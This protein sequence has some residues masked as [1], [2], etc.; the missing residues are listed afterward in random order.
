MKD[1]FIESLKVLKNYTNLSLVFVLTFASWV[2]LLIKE[3]N[4]ALRTVFVIFPV[5][6]MIIFIL[7][8]TAVIFNKIGMDND[9]YYRLLWLIPI[10]MITIYGLLKAFGDTPKKRIIASLAAAVFIA[11]FGKCVYQSPVFFKSE[12]LYGI[13]KQTIDIVDFIKADAQRDV[14]YVL[15]S[16][17]LITT[18]RQ[19]DPGIGMPYGRDTYTTTYVETN[20]VYEVYEMA[21]K[22]NFKNLLEVS[23]DY[24]V[25]YIVVYITKPTE[26]DPL[27][28]G[29]EYVG[30]VNDHLIYKDPVITARVEELKKYYE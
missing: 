12:N 6:M 15:P 26:D 25:E 24:E 30:E 20:P 11:V 17:D 27:E 18:I 28:A 22:L 13:P 5:V 10:S 9:I 2:Y 23:R 29:L 16:A 21:P 7:P 3:K 14:V 8:P 4:K 19:Y 1:I